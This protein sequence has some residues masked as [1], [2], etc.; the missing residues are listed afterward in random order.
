MSTSSLMTLR[1]LSA[2]E[3]WRGVKRPGSGEIGLGMQDEDE[4]EVEEDEEQK[5]GPSLEFIS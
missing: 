4:E 2:S 1:S 5:T 3:S